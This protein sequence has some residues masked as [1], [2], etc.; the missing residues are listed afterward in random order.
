MPKYENAAIILA[1]G[2]GKRAKTKTP[3]QFISICGKT[4][5]E[6]SLSAFDINKNINLICLVLHPIYEK[7]I[8]DSIDIKTPLIFANPG[9]NRKNSV[10]SA[11]LKL[12][13]FKPKLVIIHDSARPCVSQRLIG[14][15]F[16]GLK[17]SKAVTPVLPINDTIKFIKEKNH[18]ITKT[19]NR[20]KLYIA[21]TPQGFEYNTLIKMHEEN[22]FLSSTQVTDDSSLLEM[23]NIKVKAILGESKNIKITTRED[24][25]LAEDN[26]R[27]N[28]HLNIR[29]ALGFD[30]HPLKKSNKKLRLLGVDI[31]HDE[32][33][34]GHSDAD[35]A[36][37]AVVDALLGS[38]AKGD[39][40]KFFPD[41]KKEWKNANSAIFAKKA[42][43]LCKS[44]NSIIDFLDI[45]I[46][47]ESPIISP[48]IE[49]MK[50]NLSTIME[51]N[52][53]K[54]SIKA[55]RPEGLWLVGKQKGIAAIAVITISNYR[56]MF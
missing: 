18:L 56:D 23:Q 2:T 1:G 16:K 11:L 5:L 40:G 50:L 32:S 52:T 37:H 41:T 30:M 48:Y 15:I 7:L 43:K 12:Q 17:N 36:M 28:L 20:D 13:N 27:S 39:I 10:Y 54:I 34:V 8:L 22:K 44:S 33:L 51:I 53:D 26:L 47:C 21:Q 55:T 49:K 3:K 42:V 24:F 25:K 45:T 14:N 29:T 35:V 31:P 9:D 6:W 38:N 46:I 19:I 4:L